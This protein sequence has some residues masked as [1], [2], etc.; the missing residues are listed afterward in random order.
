[1]PANGS[2]R[3]LIER[4]AGGRAEPREIALA[5]PRS[6]NP[7]RTSLLNRS[8]LTGAKDMALSCS[9]ERWVSGSKLRSVSSVSPK[10]SRRMGQSEVGG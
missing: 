5:K 2:A 7:L 4:I 8:S 3:R 9:R 10:K 1:L 6:R